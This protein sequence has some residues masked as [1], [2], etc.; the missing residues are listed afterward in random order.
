MTG[1]ARNAAADLP[2]ATAHVEKVTAKLAFD[3]EGAP[4]KGTA[5][6]TA[7][8]ISDHAASQRFKPLLGSGTASLANGVWRGRF[9]ATDAKNT[10]LGEAKFVHTMATGAG[11]AHIDAPK[12]TF[13]LGESAAG[14]SVAVAGGAAPGRRQRRAHR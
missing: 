13:A 14:R 5:T 8:Q 9:A 6:I 11:T 10:S 3:G 12:I 2:L 1:E 4:L 7:G